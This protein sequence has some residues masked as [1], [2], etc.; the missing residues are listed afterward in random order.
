MGIYARRKSKGQQHGAGGEET[1]RVDNGGRPEEA[2]LLFKLSNNNF[3]ITLKLLYKL[4]KKGAL[5]SVELKGL[6]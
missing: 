5:T 1:W 2:L 4:I 6:G 3:R